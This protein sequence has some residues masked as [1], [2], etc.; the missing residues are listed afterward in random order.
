MSKCEYMIAGTVQS[1]AVWK[2]R[3]QEYVALLAKDCST[4]QD[5]TANERSTVTEVVN[6][7]RSIVVAYVAFLSR[8]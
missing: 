3:Q 4:Q 2:L 7:A 8:T 6:G 5:H 1:W